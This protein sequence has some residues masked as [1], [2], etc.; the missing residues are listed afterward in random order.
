MRDLALYDSDD[1]RALSAR[2]RAIAHEV[3]TMEEAARRVVDA[4]YDEFGDGNGE[5]A[6]VLVRLYKTHPYGELPADLQE[7]AAKLVDGELDPELRCFTLLATRGELPEWN[8]RR[9]SHGHRAIPLPSAQMVEMLPM[10]VQLIRQVGLEPEDVVNP[11]KGS[12]IEL[13][14]RTYDV[15]HVPEAVGSPHLPAQEEFVVKHGVASALGFGGMLYSG[16]F[17]S[18][19]LFSRVP[20]DHARAHTIK[21][22][23]LAVR[24]ALMPFTRRVFA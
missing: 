2:L 9:L 15:F 8:D 22:L 11:D 21:V 19:V 3:T 12:L 4:L 16:D 18:V 13:S 7:F 17:Y 20:I 24:V 1:L 6:T 14:Q 23:G 10:V 5:R